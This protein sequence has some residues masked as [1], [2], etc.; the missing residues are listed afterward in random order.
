VISMPCTTL[1]EQQDKAYRD[2]ILPPLSKKRLVV[3]AGTSFGWHKYSGDE[4]DIL[5]IDRFGVSAPGGIAMEKFGF[6][7]DNVVAKA[8]AVMG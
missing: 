7:V 3:E 6:T 8:K 5:S 2:A 4:G 1:F